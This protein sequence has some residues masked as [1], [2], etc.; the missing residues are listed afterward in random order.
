M[1]ARVAGRGQQRQATTGEQ[2]VYV[3]IDP[4]RAALQIVTHG[5]HRERT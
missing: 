1:G 3:G 4:S 5:E 2:R